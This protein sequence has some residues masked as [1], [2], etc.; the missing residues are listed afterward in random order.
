MSAVSSH[1]V[2]LREA[3][4]EDY[5]GIAALE[6][7]QGLVSKPFDPWRRM[8]TANPCYRNLTTHWPIGWVLTDQNRVVGCLSNIPLPYVFRGQ[9]LLVAA[10]RGWAVED[11]YRSYSL[12]LMNEYFSQENADVFLNNTVNDK[13][14]TAFSTFGSSRVPSGD[15]GTAAFTI[16]GH[17]G[18]AESALRIKKIPQQRLLS[19]P[20]GLALSLK[21][22]FTAPPIPRSRIRV[23]FERRFDQRFDI[24]W[25]RLKRH[26]STFLAVRSSQVLQWHFGPS[27]ERDAI[28]I[29]TAGSNDN[30][31]AYGIFQRRDEPQYG[32]KR[33]RMIDFQASERQD[34]YCAALMGRAYEECRA[35]GIH[36]LEQVGCDLTNTSV[37]EKSA[38]Y[39]RKLPAWSFY[40]SAKDDEL[41]AH[42]SQPTAWAPSSYDGDSSL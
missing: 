4:F 9:E 2:Q 18:F 42:L 13:A 24:F 1:P 38:P 39:R 19:Y 28:W 6:S 33:M 22:R 30:I 37:F 7:S 23:T 8:W 10:G 35:Q 3:R 16:T 15:W 11:Q 26:S 17:R 21:D 36:V 12:L 34:E 27:L 32:L 40:Y 14:A 41:A 31:Q 29:L 5:E 20:A 25:E